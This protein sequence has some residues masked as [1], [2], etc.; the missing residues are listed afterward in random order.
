MRGVYARIG[1]RGAFLAA[2]G[3]SDMFFGWYLL[4][5]APLEHALFL[6][7]RWWGAAWV[8]CGAALAVAAVMDRD[9]W[10]F[11]VAVFVKCAWAMELF[12]QAWL[13]VPYDW[14]RGGYYLGLAVLVVAVSGWPE[15]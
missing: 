15:R 8:A 5:G 1:H 2:L 4:R 11:A 12:R 13:G 9:S 3:V 14:T 7:E 10:A 6:P